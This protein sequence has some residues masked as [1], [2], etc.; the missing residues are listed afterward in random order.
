M[1]ARNFIELATSWEAF[2]MIVLANNHLK[3]S[4]LDPLPC[5]L[6]FSD[7]S[8]SSANIFMYLCKLLDT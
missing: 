7:I 8:P 3:T 1:Q 6:T 5:S 2:M 4:A